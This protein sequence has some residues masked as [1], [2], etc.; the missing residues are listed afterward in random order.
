MNFRNVPI[1]NNVPYVPK[2]KQLKQTRRT[3]KCQIALFNMLYDD[4]IIMI[5]THD[6][7]YNLA[8]TCKRLSSIYNHYLR[9]YATHTFKY[10]SYQDYTSNIINTRLLKTTKIIDLF[11]TKNGKI[12]V[13]VAPNIAYILAI[14]GNVVSLDVF[15]HHDNNVIG[16]HV[17]FP[18]C[19]NKMT[20]LDMFS[21]T[22]SFICYKC[23]LTY[24]NDDVVFIER[25]GEYEIICYNG[26]Y[27]MFIDRVMYKRLLRN[28]ISGI[29]KF[30]DPRCSES[31]TTILDVII[32]TMS[33]HII[34]AG[35]FDINPTN[36]Y[37]QHK[38]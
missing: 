22:R 11:S 19:A 8:F 26:E 3:V 6:E 5:F 15:I 30:S 16:V 18:N 34:I 35:V 23:S 36:T 2:G 25:N 32:K 1:T 4:I 17:L 9:L 21:L 31:I 10:F 7:D 24:E 33:N 27:W 12:E 37:L 13:N 38:K 29:M 28:I 20:L 14:G